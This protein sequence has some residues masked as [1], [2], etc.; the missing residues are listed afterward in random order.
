MKKNLQSIM[1]FIYI[2]CQLSANQ[3]VS[4][5][6][7]QADQDSKRV[8]ELNKVFQKIFTFLNNIALQIQPIFTK[9]V[10]GRPL[11]PDFIEFAFYIW[12]PI[13]VQTQFFC[14]L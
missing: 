5:S 2:K 13:I 7:Y 4:R 11:I 9:N 1:I 10:K 3:N 6:L 14:Y 8:I 12:R